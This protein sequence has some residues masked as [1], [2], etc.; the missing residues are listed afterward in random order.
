MSQKLGLSWHPLFSVIMPVYK[1]EAFLRDSVG[2]VIAQTCGDWELLLI[3]DGSPDSSGA[4]CDDLAA[5]DARIRV[6]HQPNRGASAA[7]NRGID[8]ARGEWI[9][10]IDA[11][12]TVD[13]RWL[14]MYACNLDADVVFQEAIFVDPDGTEERWGWFTDAEVSSYADDKDADGGVRVDGIN[15]YRYVSRRRTPS[16]STWSKCTRAAVIRDGGIRFREDISFAE[17]REMTL[18]CL[19]RSRSMRIVP[20]AGYRYLRA[21]SQLTRMRYSAWDWYVIASSVVDALDE[22]VGEYR[23]CDDEAS[24]EARSF[25]SGSLAGHVNLMLA[26]FIL[27]AAGMERQRRMEI[28]RWLRQYVPWLSSTLLCKRKYRVFRLLAWL[29]AGLFDPVMRAYS[30]L[31]ALW[32]RR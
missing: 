8:I 19:A 24:V 14:E 17:D 22:F 5:R 9:C 3:D 16:L 26:P 32:M 15:R 20:F 10:F 2:S 25:Y 7:R 13:S 18:R 4:I 21:N 1:A 31:F 12:D 27:A 28:Y 11:D 29:P 30:R 23:R 6:V